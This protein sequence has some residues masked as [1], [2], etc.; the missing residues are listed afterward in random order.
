MSTILLPEE[1]NLG[2]GTRQ[3]APPASA[4]AQAEVSAWLAA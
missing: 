2:F 3:G 1:G 4:L